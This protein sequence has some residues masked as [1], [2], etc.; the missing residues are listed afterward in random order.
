MPYF[1]PR[2]TD[3][4]LM[5]AASVMQSDAVRTLAARLK[6]RGAIAGRVQARVLA[7]L[8]MIDAGQH[9]TAW[10]ELDRCAQAL[11]WKTHVPTYSPDPL[12]N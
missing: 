7:A 9:D 2:L 3:A 6:D 12:E 5:S 1:D 4:E 10:R 11:D 8:Q